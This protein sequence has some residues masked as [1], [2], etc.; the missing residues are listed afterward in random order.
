MSLNKKYLPR[1]DI[2]FTAMFLNKKLCEEVLNIVLD[3]KVEL[4]G[5]L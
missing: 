1:K 3:E 2:V 4:V 5:I